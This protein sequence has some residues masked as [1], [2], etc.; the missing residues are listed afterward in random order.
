[1]KKIILFVIALLLI[2][3]PRSVLAGSISEQL[4]IQDWIDSTRGEIMTPNDE[5]NNKF[6][7]DN[8]PNTYL[9]FM[10]Q[11][12][13]GDFT[14]AKKIA[15]QLALKLEIGYENESYFDGEK[16]FSI[17]NMIRKEVKKVFKSKDLEKKKTLILE[18]EFDDIGLKNYKKLSKE[19][20]F[21]FSK[22]VQM[23][24]NDKIISL[25]EKE[26]KKLKAKLLKYKLI[27]E[28]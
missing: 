4:E 28:E 23:K 8:Y 7:K 24:I 1:M 10:E 18:N 3:P 9:R 11:I 13:N 17:N 20:D 26:A 12:N 5:S 27:M 15:N 21:I 22:E 25:D 19:K 6:L 14:E 16:L 2:T